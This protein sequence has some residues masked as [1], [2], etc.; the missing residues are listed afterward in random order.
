MLFLYVA[1]FSFA[2]LSL[3]TGVGALILFGMV[4]AT[5]LFSAIISGERP[6]RMEWLGLLLAIAGL[7]Y[8]M[9]PGFAAPPLLGSI[10]MAIAGVAWGFYSLR[11]RGV[12]SPLA[13]TMGNFVRAVPLAIIVFIVAI[14]FKTTHITVAGVLPAILSGALASGVGYAVWYAALHNLTAARAATVQLAVPIL[15][16]AAGVLFLAET[17]TFRVVIASVLILGGIATVIL[18]RQNT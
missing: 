18:S 13:A 3:H 14:A 8:L 9:L 11:G 17:I 2:Y 15:A 5:M 6:S 10:F 16:A 4:Q 12:N 7:V 1:G